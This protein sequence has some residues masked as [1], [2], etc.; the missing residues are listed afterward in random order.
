MSREKALGN[1]QSWVSL[2][3]Q[4][5]MWREGKNLMPFRPLAGAALGHPK[6]TST[7]PLHPQRLGLMGDER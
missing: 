3:E 6:H 5:E 4:K 7:R 1:F 2:G